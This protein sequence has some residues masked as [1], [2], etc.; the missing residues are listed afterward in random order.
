MGRLRHVLRW[1]GRELHRQGHEVAGGDGRRPAQLVLVAVEFDVRK[2]HQ[3]RVHTDVGDGAADVLPGALVRAAAER[4]VGAVA[5][6]AGGQ[7]RPDPRVDVGRE[8]G[9][10]E[11]VAPADALPA[12]LG[13]LL[14]EVGEDRAERRLVPQRLLHRLRHRHLAAVELGPEARVDQHREQHVGQQVGGGL[15]GGEE[16]QAQVLPDLVVGEAGRVADQVAGEVLLGLGAAPGGEPAEGVH[17]VG[18]AGDGG[19]GAL[20]RV[21]GGLDQTVVVIVGHAEDLAHHG[22]RQVLGELA[23]EVGLAL[24]AEAVD[25][26]LRAAV[27]VA[28]QA[29]EVDGRDG[30]HDGAAQP[31]V[32]VALGVR[33]DGLPGDVRHQRVV[34]LDQAVPQGRPDT[35]V[36]AELRGRAHHVQVL[37]VAEDD[38]H[39]HV[40]VEQHRRDGAVLLPQ[41]LVQRSQVLRLVQPVQ[42]SGPEAVRGAGGGRGVRFRRHSGRSETEVDRCMGGE[43][44]AG[45]GPDQARL[46]VIAREC[47]K[48][49]KVIST[50][51]LEARRRASHSMIGMSGVR[52]R[53]VRS[54]STA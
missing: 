2:P 7:V 48:R 44:G 8:R 40:V 27:D 19:L 33:G 54:S 4:E 50:S 10:E 13:L 46:P 16:H 1:L 35:A 26:G 23:D 30:A 53:A 47:R 39:R 49:I 14:G 34:G 51:R 32:L 22:H 25:D 29:A 12:E 15:V 17:D 36:P 24:L 45:A 5:L 3:Q 37:G 18:V 20:E 11:P 6:H 38:P 43:G 21:A 41:L 42:S 28:A 9:E 52:S 31:L